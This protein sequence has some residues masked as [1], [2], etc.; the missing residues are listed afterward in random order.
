MGAV[1]HLSEGP[2]PRRH[3]HDVHLSQTGARRAV[4]PDQEDARDDHPRDRVLDR[5]WS[6]HGGDLR[7]AAG[8]RGRQDLGLDGACVL[9]GADP[10]AGAHDRLLRR[11]QARVTPRWH[12]K[13]RLRHPRQSGHIRLSRGQDRAHD[14]A[15]S[16]ARP[17]AVRRLHADRPLRD[18]RDAGGGLRPH[19]AGEG[20]EQ[21]GDRVEA[22]IPERHAAGRH[23]D[24]PVARIHHRR[25]DHHRV[26]VRLPGHRARHRRR[27]RQT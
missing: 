3:G 15:G 12:P 5:L 6:P 14:P 21:L 7:L 27:H 1:R 26:R 2:G 17:G 10:V 23:A 9:L 25:C 19:G 11:Q 22:R 16:H 20:V 8:H 24:R 13:P 18:A 4:G